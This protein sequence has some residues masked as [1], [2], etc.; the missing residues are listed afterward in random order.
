MPCRPMHQTVGL[1][2]LGAQDGDLANQTT[3]GST[4]NLFVRQ[5]N[6][7]PGSMKMRAMVTIHL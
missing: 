4:R 6:P 3:N 2:Y 5:S 7:L 1:N